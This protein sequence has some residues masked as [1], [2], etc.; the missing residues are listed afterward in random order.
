M[1]TTVCSR[2]PRLVPQI[3]VVLWE[4]LGRDVGRMASTIAG[5]FSEL[6]PSKIRRGKK[7]LFW[8]G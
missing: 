5:T 1:R 4:C 3:P 6:I 8:D 7:T 2:I